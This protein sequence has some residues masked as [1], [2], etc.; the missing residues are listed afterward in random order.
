MANLK[1][2]AFF[3]LK[4]F[5]FVCHPPSLPELIFTEYLETK[6]RTQ[7]TVNMEKFGG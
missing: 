6:H 2:T 4:W 3:A 7:N 5:I 1:K